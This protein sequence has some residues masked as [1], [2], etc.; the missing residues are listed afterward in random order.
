MKT[1]SPL[2]LTVVLLSTV[3]INKSNGQSPF[4]SLVWTF[5]WM[6]TADQNQ[7]ELSRNIWWS[8]SGNQVFCWSSGGEV[9]GVLSRWGLQDLL[10]QTCWRYDVIQR[11]YFSFSGNISGLVVAR[12]CATK[13]P[14]FYVECENHQSKRNIEEFCYCSFNFCNSH[15]NSGGVI[16]TQSFCIICLSLFSYTFLD[17][18]L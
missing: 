16:T 1:L 9:S 3:W 14:V 2:V 11:K 10:Y 12:G 18:N 8:G 4:S 15:S 7:F 5:H 13:A 17:K 6:S